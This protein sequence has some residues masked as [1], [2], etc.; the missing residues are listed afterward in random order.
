MA[1]NS[2]GIGEGF[3]KALGLAAGEVREIE[4]YVRNNPLELLRIPYVRDAV[5][6]ARVH[7]LKTED[8]RT[9][10][11]HD[12]AVI[13][14]TIQHNLSGL[15]NLAALHRP[16]L[17]INP[18][19]SSCYF[20]ENHRSFE[21]LTVGPRTE[22]EIFALMAA[23]IPPANIR[24]LDLIS[25]SP[26]VDLGDMHHMPYA[27]D[28]F[29]VVLL[30]WVLGYSNDLARVAREVLRVARPGALVA[31]GHE[32]DP[33]SKDELDAERGFALDGTGF[34]STDEMLAL[35][36]PHVDAVLFR[37]DVHPSLRHVVSHVM[38]LFQLVM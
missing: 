27:D 24:G 19:L 5:T 36:A 25:Y 11:D 26:F 28:R 2:T 34:K 7:R 32:N 30:G 9:L 3:Q 35:F 4:A 17:L 38:V 15:R 6:A 1:S 13:E 8:V 12:S 29:D 23:G 21:V 37:H 20:L 18:L 31:I 33:N 22:A 10:R 14:N 16:S